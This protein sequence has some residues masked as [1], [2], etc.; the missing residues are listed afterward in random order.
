VILHEVYVAITH[1]G[2]AQVYR[3]LL[4]KVRKCQLLA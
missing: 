4:A 2:Q 3:L 1:A